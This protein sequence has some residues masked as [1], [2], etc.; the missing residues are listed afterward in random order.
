MIC[1][2][3]RVGKPMQLGDDENVAISDKL[4]RRLELASHSDR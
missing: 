4:Q 2:R 1:R 3:D